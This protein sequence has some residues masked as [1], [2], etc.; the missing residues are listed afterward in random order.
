[1]ELVILNPTEIKVKEGMDRYRQDMGDIKSLA[2]SIKRTRQI[3]PIVI[4]RNNELMDGGRRLAA[5]ILNGMKV[6]AVYEDVVD[7]Y[8]MRELELEGNLHRLD[9][10][11]A[12]YAFA[13][14]DLHKMKI[15]KF[16]EGGAGRKVE[17]DTSWTIEDTA[18]LMGKTRSVVYDALE[19]ADLVERYPVLKQ[20]KTKSEIK[21]AGKS[22]QKLQQTI[23]GLEKNKETIE[24]GNKLFKIIQGDA[25]EYMLSCPTGSIDILLTDPLYGIEADKLMQ[26]IGGKTGGT[27]SSSGYKI[28]DSTDKAMLSYQIL[29]KES[30][31]F[32]KDTAHAY[33]FVGPEHFWTLRN[34]FME[35]NWRVHVKPLIWIK[36]EVGQ[37]NVPHA[38]PASC[39]EML[40][41]AR[42]DNSRLIQEG[43]PDWIECPPVDPSKRRHIYEKPTALIRNL[44][45][46]VS[47]PGQ[48]VLD[49]FLGSGSV[50]EAATQL[51]LMSIGIEISSEAYANALERMSKY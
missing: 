12:E 17:G 16:G 49:P 41:Y 24:A 8:E 30:F 20:A 34:V 27:F 39:Y 14:R 33:I 42:K 11:P 26:G 38:W 47:L 22:L 32:T 51:R 46:R 29:A 13:V 9:Y 5:C 40:M 37:C 45:E 15:E 18:K 6:K 23:E 21:K 44:L 4:N 48:T 36:R 10:S 7:A 2:E 1:M 50:L 3:L 35:A 43:K 19:M 25:I 31:R 28:D